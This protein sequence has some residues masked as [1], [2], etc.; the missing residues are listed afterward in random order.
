MTFNKKLKL[1]YKEE[2]KFL[3]RGRLREDIV[4]IVVLGPSGCTC[5]G[6]SIFGRCDGTRIKVLYKSKSPH[7]TCPLAANDGLKLIP[8]QYVNIRW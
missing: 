5:A 6:N 1:Y 3:Y 4:G 7:N 2:N 8:I